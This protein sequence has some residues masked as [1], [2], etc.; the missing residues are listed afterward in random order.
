MWVKM[1]EE[2]GDADAFMAD[3]SAPLNR[4]HPLNPERE[5]QDKQVGLLDPAGFQG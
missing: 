1:E 5:E 3:I 2:I 4:V